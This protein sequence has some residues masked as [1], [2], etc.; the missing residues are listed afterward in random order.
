[1][2]IKWRYIQACDTTINFLNLFAEILWL[3]FIFWYSI[4]F[5][6]FTT[7]CLV[8]YVNFSAFFFFFITFSRFLQIVVYVLFFYFIYYIFFFLL[9]TTTF[10]SWLS[11]PLQKRFRDAT[12]PSNQRPY[13]FFLL[14]FN[15]FIFSSI[16]FYF[17][18]FVFLSL[19]FPFYFYIF[20]PRFD[21]QV[22][23]WGVFFVYLFIY[24][25]LIS[26]TISFF[27][28]FSLVP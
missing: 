7:Q 20:L 3:V 6:A 18:S 4:S 10:Y 2:V 17:Y 19:I 15:P 26:S 16:Y 11:H 25:F 8:Y 12:V 23:R 5:L 21:T 13:F 27:F 28:F 24:F 9:P 22:W 14:L 1:M